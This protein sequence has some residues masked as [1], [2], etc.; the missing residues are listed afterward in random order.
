MMQLHN[1]TPHTPRISNFSAATSSPQHIHLHKNSKWDQWKEREEEEEEIDDDFL[2][3]LAWG[4]P[5]VKEEE[6]IARVFF[7]PLPFTVRMERERD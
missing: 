7:F 6:D 3:L 4:D 1:P 5:K 2:R